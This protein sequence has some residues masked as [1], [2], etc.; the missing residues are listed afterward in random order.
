MA[1]RLWLTLFAALPC[2]LA[3]GATAQTPVAAA[4]GSRTTVVGC[5]EQTQATTDEPAEG[6]PAPTLALFALSLFHQ[7]AHNGGMTTPKGS[8]PISSDASVA[9]SFRR[10][11]AGVRNYAG[12][13]TPRGST[14]VRPDAS[15]SLAS[16]LTASASYNH[17]GMMSAKGSVPVTS[18]PFGA[19]AY[20]LASDGRLADRV[21]QVV[22]VTGPVE[23][24]AGERILTVESLRV[25]SSSC[26]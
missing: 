15:A 11:I 19:S 14:P 26:Q 25:V 9:E 12:M 5:I 20:G 18:S 22:E 8:T 1:Q 23:T 6:R 3:V 13:T 24:T 17:A 16:Q 7:P 4:S 10:E 21:G 2:L